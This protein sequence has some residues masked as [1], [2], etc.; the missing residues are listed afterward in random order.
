MTIRK[1]FVLIIGLVSLIAI[2]FLS[3]ATYWFSMKNAELEAK[4]KAQIIASYQDATQRYFQERQKPLIDLLIEQDRFYPELMSRFALVRI[5]NQYFAKEMPGYKV[6]SASL[7]PLKLSN[8][9]DSDEVKIINRFKQTKLKRQKGLMQ[10]NGDPYFFYA[11]PQMVKKDCLS[12]HSSPDDASKD[13]VA[14]YGDKHGYGWEAGEINAATI[15]YVPF[16]KVL[17]EAKANA[18]KIFLFGVV[19]F[20]IC[21]L[22]ITFSIYKYIVHPVV[23]LSTRVKEISLGQTLEESVSYNRKDE[24]GTLAASINR[25]RISIKKMMKRQ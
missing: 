16:E 10:K 20:G 19:L 23:Y 21:M 25:L 24:I 11:K 1:R 3:L 8:K 2:S 15:I 5:I 6:K 14:I 12:C 7:N 9:A 22:I 17:A 18:M 4:R 13:Q